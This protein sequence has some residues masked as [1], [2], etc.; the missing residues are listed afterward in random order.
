[1]STEKE[2]II[3]LVSGSRYATMKDH[4]EIIR[5]TLNQVI[6]NGPIT[7]VHGGCEGVD[8]ICDKIGKERNWIIDAR[9]PNWDLYGK[10]AGPIRNTEMLKTRPHYAFAFPKGVS[11]GTRDCKKKMDLYAKEISSRLISPVIQVELK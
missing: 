7:L 10:K 2:G 1:M 9:K 5:Q 4:G 3:V 6:H 8:L 11:A